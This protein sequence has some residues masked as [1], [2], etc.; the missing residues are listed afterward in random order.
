MDK[1]FSINAG[2]TLDGPLVEFGPTDPNTGLALKMPSHFSRRVHYESL[3]IVAT[4]G[5]IFEGDKIELAE[6]HLASDGRYIST[7]ALTQLAL[8]S[9]ISALALEVIPGAAH[10][11]QESLPQ[12]VMREPSNY[13][14]QVY[15]FEH[16]SWGGPRARVMALMNWSRTNANF[17][18]SKWA[19]QHPMP[20]AH[21][22]HLSSH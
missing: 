17:H 20:G 3:G 2:T 9:V 14:A 5:C 15:W 6:L 4:F 1:L 13:L 19:K 12:S 18:I 16:V 10:W 8:P 11:T 7:K 22:I 21:S